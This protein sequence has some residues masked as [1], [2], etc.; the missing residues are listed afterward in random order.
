MEFSKL[1]LSL[2]IL[3]SLFSSRASSSDHMY[4]VGDEVP[5]FVNKVGPL[6]NPS[7]TYQYYEMP[8]CLPDKVLPKKE[9]LGEVLNGDR[10]T[11]SLYM[12]KFKLDNTDAALCQKKINQNDIAKFRNAIAMDYYFQMYYDDL[13]LWGFIGKVEDNSWSMDG[14]AP[15]YFLFK[16]IQFNALH[17]NNQIIEI[18]AFSDPNSAVDITDDV[19]LDITFTYSVFWNETS[20]PFKSR[21]NRYLRASLLPVHQKIHWFSCVNSVVIIVLLF[22]LLAFLFMQNLRNDLRRNTGGDEEENKE[23]GWKCIQNDIFRCPLSMP[24][25][26]AALGTG[27]QL[28]TLVL[29]LFALAFTGILYPQSRGALSTSIIIVYTLTSAVA[30]YTSASF[31]SQFAKTGWERSVFLAGTLFFGPFIFIAFTL[32]LVAAYFGTT[33]ALPF[34]TIFVLVI[35]H[36]VIGIPLL[37]LGGLRGCNFRPEFQESHTNRKF[38]REVP[39]STWYCRIPGQMFI[40]GLLPFS[41]IVMELHQLYASIWGYK[42]FTLPGILFITFMILVLVTAVLSI[43]LTY[44]QLTV[45]DPDWWWRSF[46]RGGS[47]GIFMFLYSFYFYSKS[48]MSGFMQTVFYFGYSASMCYAFFLMLGTV[49]FYTSL[50]FVRRIYHAVK[51]E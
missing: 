45:E 14:K 25:F 16:H 27:A 40:A 50:T 42:I 7:E 3:Q 19:D 37:A 23:I 34:G 41:A 2:I 22:G 51:S 48:S 11:N 39:P 12:L 32:N 26:C 46:L 28:L 47:V 31:Y 8:F 43:L 4:N 30:G 35:V 33:A 36:M 13:P 44:F 17:N 18:H 5:F 9:S 10:L 49:S 15:T 6:N 21:M 24:L 38:S 29:V 20:T 1:L